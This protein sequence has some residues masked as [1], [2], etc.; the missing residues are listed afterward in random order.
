MKIPA[1]SDT[2]SGV[3]ASSSVFVYTTVTPRP[4]PPKCHAF[5]QFLDAF[6]SKIFFRIFWC[7]LT[8]HEAKSS[9]FRFV[10]NRENSAKRLKT[11]GQTKVDLGSKAKGLNGGKAKRC[12]VNGTAAVEK[13]CP[14]KFVFLCEI[15][16]FSENMNTMADDKL[17][18]ETFELVNEKQ[19]A[20]PKRKRREM[21][22]EQ[23]ATAVANLAKGRAKSLAARRAKAEAK[24]KNAQPKEAPTPQTV[25]VVAPSTATSTVFE[26]SAEPPPSAPEKKK[27]EKRAS[28]AD[29]AKMMPKAEPKPE[30]EPEP[31]KA[32]HAPEP[33]PEPVKQNQ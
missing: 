29:A 23:K 6:T 1:G 10:I 30:P 2:Q 26:T 8:F 13:K 9:K 12:L 32:T 33:K 17:A 27:E 28:H 25:S 18:N 21:T 5:R 7:A 24:K 14:R 20:K 11:H 19:S 3:V 16:F 22:P 15:H 31:V 4:K